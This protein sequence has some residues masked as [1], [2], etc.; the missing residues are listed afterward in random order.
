MVGALWCKVM[1]RL[2][3]IV[4]IAALVFVVWRASNLL[5]QAIETRARAKTRRRA[6]MMQGQREGD[7][8]RA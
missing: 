4:L 6:S 2:S 3:R 7:A 5:A 8:S 1:S